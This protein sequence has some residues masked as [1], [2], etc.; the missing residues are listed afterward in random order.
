MV[1]VGPVAFIR[2]SV[3]FVLVPL[4]YLAHLYPLTTTPRG[5]AS[6]PAVMS[7]VLLARLAVFWGV[8]R[9]TFPWLSRSAS[10]LC[11]GYLVSHELDEL[12][13]VTYTLEALP[14]VSRASMGRRL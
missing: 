5:L 13:A 1:T 8:K 4:P 6:W 2:Y 9:T 11:D 3:L 14:H 10:A 7:L 12:R